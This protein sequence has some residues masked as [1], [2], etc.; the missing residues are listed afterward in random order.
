[1]CSNMQKSRKVLVSWINFFLSNSTVFFLAAKLP[2]MLLWL[3]TAK[4]DRLRKLKS[5]IFC[6]RKIISKKNRE[7]ILLDPVGMGISWP[8]D[9]VV[10][11]ILR[12]FLRLCGDITYLSESDS[13]KLWYPMR[14]RALE[15]IFNGGFYPWSTQPVKKE[16]ENE[17]FVKPL[18]CD[19]KFRKKSQMD[20]FFIHQIPLPFQCRRKLHQAQILGLFCQVRCKMSGRR[21]CSNSIECG[22]KLLS[23]VYVYPDD[24]WLIPVRC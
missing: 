14:Y 20:Q 8:T 15:W 6:N 4:N 16:N 5:H 22:W 3:R 10:S 24:S 13:L 12:H 23:N 2:W 11:S 17:I 9:V 19:K 7:P 18:C 21:R 1:M